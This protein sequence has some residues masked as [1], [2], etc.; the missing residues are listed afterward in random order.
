MTTTVVV[1]SEGALGRLVGNTD[2]M[3][4]LV[5]VTKSVVVVS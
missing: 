3:K 1:I 5:G 4:E 2:E